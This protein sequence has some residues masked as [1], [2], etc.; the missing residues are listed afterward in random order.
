[1]QPIAASLPALKHSTPSTAVSNSFERP[2]AEKLAA[3]KQ[4]MKTL[5]KGRPDTERESPQY[6]AEMVEVLA[7]LTPEEL[8]WLTHPRDGLH[9]ACK[10]LPTPADVHEF[11]REKRKRVE[12]FKPAPT[13]WKKIE[14]D[15]KAPWN[16]ET[17]SDRKRRVVIE[18]L[19]YDPYAA[20]HPRNRTLTPPTAADLDNLVI[21]TPVGPPSRYLIDLLRKDGWPFIPTVAAPELDGR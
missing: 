13:N 5:M 1:M 20:N 15:P 10:F 14:D 16:L 21:K 17:D 12:Q 18:A 9:T 11:I 4:A 7:W 6:L 3:A 2:N 8:A 19:G